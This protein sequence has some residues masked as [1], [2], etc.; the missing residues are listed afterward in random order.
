MRTG[1]SIMV[2]LEIERT[3]EK[4]MPESSMDWVRRKEDFALYA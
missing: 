1:F 4:C 2:E 3:P